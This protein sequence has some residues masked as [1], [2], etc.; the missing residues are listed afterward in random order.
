[1]S[2]LKKDIRKFFTA[3]MCITLLTGCSGNNLDLSHLIDN[4]QEQVYDY[5]VPKSKPSI[6][7]NQLGYHPSSVKNVIF[8]GEDIPDT[9]SIIDE[10]TQEVVYTGEIEKKGYQQDARIQVGE[11]VFT[12]F[13]K[14]GNYY[15][16]CDTIGQSYHF[17]VSDM[18]HSN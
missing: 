14:E 5:E 12:D 8:I 16:L 17:S 2:R 6:L 4:E 15:I 3:L 11:G 13:T 18:S 10:K 9:F 7:V 1:M